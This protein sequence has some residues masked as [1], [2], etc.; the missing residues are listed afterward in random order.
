[1]TLEELQNKS[2][3]TIG[4]IEELTQVAKYTIRYWEKTF[5][6]LKPIRKESG[7]RRYT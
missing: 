4:E 6:L 3:F 5:G 2:Y 1:M 7:H